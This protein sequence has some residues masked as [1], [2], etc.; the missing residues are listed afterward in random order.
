MKASP[1]GTAETNIAICQRSPQTLIPPKY[2]RLMAHTHTCNLVHCVFS[3]K[4]RANLIDVTDDPTE[5]TNERRFCAG[6]VG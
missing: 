4:D 3:T 5:V 2:L 6:W 1:L